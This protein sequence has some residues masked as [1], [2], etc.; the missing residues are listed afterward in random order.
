MNTFHIGWDSRS[1]GG[2]TGFGTICTVRWGFA[3]GETAQVTQ[4]SQTAGEQ[5]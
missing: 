5:I 4:S 1:K 2:G 3:L